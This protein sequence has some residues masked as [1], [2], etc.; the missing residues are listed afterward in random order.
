MKILFAGGGTGGHLFSGIPVAEAFS[1]KGSE[2]L[3]VG[4]AYG[5]E[6]QIIPSLGYRL[7]LIPVKQLKGKGILHRLKTIA[8][9]PYAFWKSFRLLRR[10][11][12]DLVLG[13][14][15]YASGP[16]TLM[17]RFMGIKTAIIEQNSYPGF[18]NRVL[19]KFVHRVFIAFENARKFFAP[20]KTFLTGNPVRKEFLEISLGP[21]L[22]KG[23]GGDFCLLVLGG[24]QG[25]HSINVAMV[26]AAKLLVGAQHGAPLRI[27]HQTG[28]ADFEEVRA[29][30]EKSGIEARVFEFI[31]DVQNYYLQADLV[32]SR[33]GA[34]TITELQNTGRP[35]ILI[36]YP[37]A[38]DDHQRTNAEELVKVGGAR[39]ILNRDL[40]GERLTQEIEALRKD[41][42]LL[43]SMEE[44]SKKLAKPL[45]AH[46]I[47]K[48][49]EGLFEGGRNSNQRMKEAG[50]QKQN[51]SY[52][53]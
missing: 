26:E 40:T 35:S 53:Q 49:C 4:T 33:S 44:Q 39:M 36:P 20:E 45:A 42:K 41:S 48:I 12:P 32:I 43:A 17:A 25:A 19:G 5:L 3:F 46:E 34:G 47:L 15:G 7:E 38:A 50:P 37:Y 22:K 27:I 9:I 6:N 14:G 8:Q 11:K 10:E 13:I 21:P 31:R 23:G 24:S 52:P 18:T 51:R 28:K 2:V 16:V 29:A 1:E 30:Y